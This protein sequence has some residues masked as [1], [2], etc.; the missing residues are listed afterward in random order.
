MEPLSLF[1]KIAPIGTNESGPHPALVFLHGRGTDENDLLGLAPYIDPHFL[2]ASVRAPYKFPYGGNTWFDLDG[3]NDVNIDQLLNSCDSFLRWLEDFKQKYPVDP[4]RL[5][6]FGFSMGA[7]MSLAISLSNPERFK[8]IVV[9][10][11]LLPQHE[12]LAYRWN[13]LGPLSFFI[14][15]GE[16]DSVVP[17]DL[18]RQAHRLLERAKADILYREYPIQHTISDESLSDISTWLQ[19]QI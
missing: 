12:R 11:G 19:R 1:S 7:M 4:S 18:G 13:D 15:H 6:L 10:S 16:Q 2:I 9:H 17:I 8:G 14:A 5:F 3:H